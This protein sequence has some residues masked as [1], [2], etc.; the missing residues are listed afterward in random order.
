M[1]DFADALVTRET[2]TRSC[3]SLR[4]ALGELPPAEFS[5]IELA[6][7]RGHTLR[8][9]AVATVHRKA[10]PSLGFVGRF[11]VSSSTWSSSH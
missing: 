7:F 10:L 5:A 1:P 4:I 8:E 9:V 3:E 11:D 2:S 6:Y